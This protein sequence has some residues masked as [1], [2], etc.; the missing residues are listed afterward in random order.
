MKVLGEIA[1]KTEILNE[2]FRR[3]FGRGFS[4]LENHLTNERNRLKTI[5]K[6]L[7]STCMN[8]QYIKAIIRATRKMF[9]NL[10]HAGFDL[11]TRDSCFTILTFSRTIF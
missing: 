1:L 10:N 3:H 4:I 9:K 2:H 6:V 7:Y 5:I 11:T 8:E